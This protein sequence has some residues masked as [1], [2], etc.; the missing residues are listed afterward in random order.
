M[1]NGIPLSTSKTH[2][3]ISCSAGP[4]TYNLAGT[5]L[6]TLA[7]HLFDTIGATLC[8]VPQYAYLPGRGTDDALIRVFRHCDAVRTTCQSHRFPLQQ[9]ALGLKPGPLEGGL[10]VT[11]DLSKAFDMV[12]R[13]RLFRCLSN[14]GVPSQLIDFLNVVYFDTSFSFQHRGQT[15][16]LGTSRGIRQGCKAAPTLWAAYI[17]EILLDCGHNIDEQWL[18]DCLTMYADDGCMHEVVTSPE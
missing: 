15:R 4:Q 1:D 9:M 3:K 7:S 11:L 8:S 6:G 16:H 10:L 12:P 13:G 17:T 18:Y 14:F 2:Q 5:L